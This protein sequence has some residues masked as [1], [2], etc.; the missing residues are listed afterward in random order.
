MIK[1]QFELNYNQKK[2]I[3][4]LFRE[5]KRVEKFD[6]KVYLDECIEYTIHLDGIKNQMVFNH[7]IDCLAFIHR[8]CKV[9]NR[10]IQNIMLHDIAILQLKKMYYHHTIVSH[11]DLA[12]LVD[13][14]DNIEQMI[15]KE[16]KS[17]AEKVNE[18]YAEIEA[19]KKIK[20]VNSED[21]RNEQNE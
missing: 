21:K 4:F 11:L 16:K 7:P 15:E 14:E 17:T 19:N 1:I 10:I 20:E 13:Y 8:Y 18:Y 9:E 12:Q 2:R 6:Q 5:V 3:A